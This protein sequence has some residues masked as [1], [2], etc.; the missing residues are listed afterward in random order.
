MSALQTVSSRIGLLC[1]AMMA[2]CRVPAARGGMAIGVGVMWVKVCAGL[3]PGH[4]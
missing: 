3:F 4:N 1:S 2:G